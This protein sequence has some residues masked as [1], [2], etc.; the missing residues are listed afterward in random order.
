MKNY[1]LRWNW[2]I[3]LQSILKC[4]T[5]R[6][7]CFP[8]SR[9]TVPKALQMLSS[10]SNSTV[11]WS[12]LLVEMG[13][14][15]V[16]TEGLLMDIYINFQSTWSLMITSVASKEIMHFGEVCSVKPHR[17]FTSTFYFKI[18]NCSGLHGHK[19]ILMFYRFVL[20]EKIEA[21]KYHLV[22]QLIFLFNN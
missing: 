8:T 20:L 11:T 9:I 19:N 5:S 4:G 22:N 15:L 21:L 13:F 14:I 18:A 6:R 10:S 3:Y 12:H 7:T 16:I 2:N 1:W 17:L